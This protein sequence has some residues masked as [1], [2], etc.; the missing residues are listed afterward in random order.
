MH[1]DPHQVHLVEDEPQG[2]YCAP[3][4]RGVGD[5]EGRGLPRQ[6]GGRPGAPLSS[7]PCGVRSTSV[8]PVNRFSRFQVLSPC[9]SNT[10]SIIACPHAVSSNTVRARRQAR[11]T[12]DR[13][14]A[15]SR[16]HPAVPRPVRKRR[17]NSSVH[18]TMR[19]PAAE[20]RLLRAFA[21]ACGVYAGSWLSRRSN[22]KAR[23]LSTMIGGAWMRLKQLTRTCRI[24]PLEVVDEGAGLRGSTARNRSSSA[25]PM[26][27]SSSPVTVPPQD[28]I[29][30]MPA[31]L[32]HLAQH[33]VVVTVLD[34]IAESP[35]DILGV[36]ELGAR[37]RV[38]VDEVAGNHLAAEHDVSLR[39]RASAKTWVL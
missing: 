25:H 11:R 16:C 17:G 7:S 35:G 27:S 34:G 37:Y 29:E 26:R 23:L 38:A 14:V 10:R 6:A 30:W 36:G 13:H 39:C 4:Q 20:Q 5:I 9:L 31:V 1:R 3:E 12:L 32:D 18:L 24:E 21:Q 19:L 28:E 2:A 8:H 15:R 22:P 33:R